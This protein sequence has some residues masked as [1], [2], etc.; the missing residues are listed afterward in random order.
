MK[1][2]ISFFFS[3]SKLFS[4]KIF[5]RQFGMCRALYALDCLDFEFFFLWNIFICVLLSTAPYPSH[6]LSYL[7][8]DAPNHFTTKKAPAIAAGA[9]M[10]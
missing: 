7:F 5:S 4:F 10:M 8:A 2:M 3:I 9:A 6:R 1:F